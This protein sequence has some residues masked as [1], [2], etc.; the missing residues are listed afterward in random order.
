MR[1]GEREQNIIVRR[2]RLQLEIELAA[3]ALAQR[4]AKGPVDA[5]PTG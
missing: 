3:K 2:G 4:E 1:R 5:A